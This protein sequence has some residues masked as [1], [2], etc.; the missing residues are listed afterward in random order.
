MK[1]AYGSMKSAKI[2]FQP[3]L[4]QTY[5]SSTTVVLPGAI[6]LH[7][8][9]N[10]DSYNSIIACIWTASVASLHRRRWHVHRWN[11]IC[12]PG[13]NDYEQDKREHATQTFIDWVP[14][15]RTRRGPDLEL[16][17]CSRTCFKSASRCYF[18]LHGPNEDL[19]RADSCNRSPTGWAL[20]SFRKTVE[21]ISDGES[22]ASD[23]I[24]RRLSELRI[25]ARFG[26]SI[27]LMGYAILFQTMLQR[28]FH[29]SA[30]QNWLLR[31]T[32]SHW[33]MRLQCELNKLQTTI[34]LPQQ[35]FPLLLPLCDGYCLYFLFC[36]FNLST[37]THFIN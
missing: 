15:G 21:E 5:N 37:F 22:T 36:F 10:D 9:T 31:Y 19:I 25:K 34:I 23:K 32:P 13:R 1:P 2:V 7:C 18:F 12:A 11:S 30:R 3:M 8:V 29:T 33:T 6:G 14:I 16:A 17:K 26:S 28:V 27:I 4:P 35:L 24:T 20:H